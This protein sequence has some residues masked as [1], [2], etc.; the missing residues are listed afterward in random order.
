MRLEVLEKARAW[1]GTPFVPEA[2]LRGIGTDCV[3]LIEGIA[4]E[5]G[6]A[7]PDRQSL[8]QD[9][10]AAAHAFLRPCPEPVPGTLILLSQQPFGPPVHAGLVSENGRFIHAHWTAG[11]VENRYGSWFSVRTTHVFDWP[12]MI[13]SQAHS[14]K[15]EE[16]V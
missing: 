10:E 15:S 3:G 8:N 13:P 9:L 1:L 4:R 11:V 14:I 16:R 6:M 5:L 7:C 2:S 12:A